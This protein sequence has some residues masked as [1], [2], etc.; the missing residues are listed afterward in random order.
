MSSCGYSGL[1]DILVGPSL[2]AK[3]P[4]QVLN[5]GQAPN[6]ATIFIVAKR[7]TLHQHQI[8][9]ILSMADL[10]TVLGIRNW[11]LGDSIMFVSSQPH[12]FV[13]ANWSSCIEHGADVAAST[14]LISD[15]K[16]CL[17]VSHL[18]APCEVFGR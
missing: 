8:G 9:C 6:K 3:C 4:E 14:G 16:T 7:N 13:F 17:K 1:V 10:P 11:Q 15:K 5:G 12:F 18:R 2:G